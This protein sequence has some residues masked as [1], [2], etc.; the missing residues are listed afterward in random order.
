MSDPFCGSEAR[1]EKEFGVV[2][3]GGN[4]TRAWIKNLMPATTYDIT[5]RAKTRHKEPGWNSFLE[6][7]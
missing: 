2:S 3:F 1:H 7:A 4:E 5:V 6:T